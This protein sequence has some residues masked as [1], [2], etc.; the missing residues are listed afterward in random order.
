MSV[1]L[2]TGA[3]PSVPL[4]GARAERC[5]GQCPAG[6]R[7]L[8]SARSRAAHYGAPQERWRLFFLG[9]RVP[10]IDL[11]FP[12]PLHYSFQR[13]NL[14]GGDKY[15]F[16]HA[17]QNGA[18]DALFDRSLRASITVRDAIGDLPPIPSGGGASEM[19]HT[20]EAAS[21]YQHEIRKGSW[22]VYNHEC[23][24]VSPINIERMQY[25][26]PGGSWRDIPFRLLP[27]GMQRARRS[28]H[29]KRYGR[30]HPEKLSPTIMTKC[31]LHWGTVFHYGQ[32][33][34]ISVREAARIQSFPD[35]FRFTGW[36]KDQYRQVG[37]AVPPELARA[38]AE[39][40][41]R[42]LLTSECEANEDAPT[43]HSCAAG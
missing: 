17:V 4:S 31:D 20:R 32:D 16:K 39:H 34:I 5:A 21:D 41:K 14:T 40:I 13:P 19:E 27:K 2:P 23:N 29:T 11:S 12:P 18:Q 25:V 36:K 26:K 9:T 42:W 33:R 3:Y 6:A 10:G 7:P 22:R 43:H 30:L 35:W 37:N 1:R 28:N 15:I 38:I 24:G 8:G